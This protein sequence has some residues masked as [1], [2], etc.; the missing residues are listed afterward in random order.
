[1]W[2]VSAKV[3]WPSNWP[4]QTQPKSRK[5]NLF[6]YMVNSLDLV[7]FFGAVG[8][9]YRGEL[10]LNF[11]ILITCMQYYIQRSILTIAW[12]YRGLCQT[13]LFVSNFLFSVPRVN[14]YEIQQ[15]AS[16]HTDRRMS[17]IDASILR[18]CST[19]EYTIYTRKT[20]N[21]IILTTRTY[22]VRGD[23]VGVLGAGGRGDHA[24]TTSAG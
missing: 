24:V 3:Q 2:V 10:L 20:Q 19:C 13:K 23:G 22:L 17:I 18:F 5:S 14:F 1:M 7:K 8:P 16:G 11:I 6:Q 12:Y 9:I 4:S 21:C 15:D